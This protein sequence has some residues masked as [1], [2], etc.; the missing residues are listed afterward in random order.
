SSDLGHREIDHLAVVPVQLASF[1]LVA[2]VSYDLDV[3]QTQHVVPSFQLFV[4]NALPARTHRSLRAFSAAR[5]LRLT[6]RAE[7]PRALTD[8]SAYA[9][10]RV[11]GSSDSSLPSGPWVGGSI[12]T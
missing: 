10:S 9:V 4:R 12:E 11:T 1:W 6:L 3:V 2:Q 8:G 7:R 5:L